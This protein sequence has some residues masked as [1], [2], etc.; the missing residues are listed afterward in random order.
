MGI[1][2]MMVASGAQGLANASNQNVAAQQQLELENMR[3]GREDQREALRQ[4]YLERN[5]NLQREDRK[6]QAATQMQFDQLKY[7]RG[8]EDKLSDAE[9]EHRRKLELTGLVES[10]RDR[11]N[12]NSIAAANQRAAARSGGSAEGGGDF[13]KMESPAGKAAVDLMH[14]KLANNERDAYNMAI[15]LD[16]VKAAQQNP[17]TKINDDTLLQSVERLT[18]GLFPKNG[19]LL[20]GGTNTAV[21][22]IFFELD[23]RTGKPVPKWPINR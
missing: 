17:L 18:Q 2:G 20:T 22:E 13:P 7:Q 23:P 6:E 21:P 3:A 16:V 5:F 15:K 12:A 19:S 10:G 8:R 9:V 14:L 11:R 1:L 4:K